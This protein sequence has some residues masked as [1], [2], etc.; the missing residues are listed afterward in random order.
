[1]DHLYGFDALI[2]VCAFDERNHS[3]LFKHTP[4]FLALYDIYLV[5]NL[6]T[7]I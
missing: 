6:H 2:H 4:F 5:L 3:Q 7:L 1:M